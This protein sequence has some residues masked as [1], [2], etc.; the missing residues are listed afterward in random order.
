MVLKTFQVSFQLKGIYILVLYEGFLQ[1]NNAI[2]Y[3]IHLF[4][5]LRTIMNHS[6]HLLPSKFSFHNDALLKD[7][8]HVGV[9]PEREKSK[10]KWVVFKERMSSYSLDQDLQPKRK[11]GDMII[12]MTMKMIWWWWQWYRQW[13]WPMIQWISGWSHFSFKIETCGQKEKMIWR[14]WYIWW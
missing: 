5:L 10:W 2:V 4:W 1:E 11:D 9:K 14:W 7:L 3:Y 13:K 8:I 12:V 6:Q